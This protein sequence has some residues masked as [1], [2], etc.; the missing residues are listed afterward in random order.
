MTRLA[1]E[2]KGS[3]HN[4]RDLSQELH[5]PFPMVGKILK[6]IAKSGLLLSVRGSK[7]G[8]S[9][10]RDPR[11]ISVLDL[12]AALEGPIAMTDCS[13]DSFGNCEQ[14]PFC[15]VSQN[16]QRINGVV[17][18]ALGGLSLAE[19]ARPLPAKHFLSPVQIQI[20]SAANKEEGR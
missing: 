7:G 3:M 13:H 11:E 6:L 4:A 18:S 2:P 19:M 16:W 20:S 15:P 9:L 14:E 17:R 1:R 10:A 5:L 12:I 8:Y